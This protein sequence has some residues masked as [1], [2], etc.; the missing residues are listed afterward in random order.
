[1]GELDGGVK[2]MS[3][4]TSLARSIFEGR[5]ISLEVT[6]PLLTLQ[7]TVSVYSTP[8]FNMMIKV[9]VP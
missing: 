7:F 6:L 4:S 3:S 1:L 5:V 9:E 2:E 8:K